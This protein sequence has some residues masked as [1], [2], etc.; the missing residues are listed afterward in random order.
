MRSATTQV[1]ALTLPVMCSGFT[2]LLMLFSYDWC[3]SRAFYIKVFICFYF[4]FVGK[5][6]KPKRKS[7]LRFSTEVTHNGHRL[8]IDRDGDRRLKVK[9]SRE[10]REI[11]PSVGQRL[12][13]VSDQ[14]KSSTQS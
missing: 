7:Q 8:P 2:V 5:V 12:N 11:L 3:V 13:R 14:R 9:D 10:T 6:S 1:Y 4:C